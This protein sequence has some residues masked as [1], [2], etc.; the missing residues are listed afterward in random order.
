MSAPK[1]SRV[2][3]RFM[4]N[5]ILKGSWHKLGSSDKQKVKDAMRQ[6]KTFKESKG[7]ISFL[8]SKMTEKAL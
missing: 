7:D 2:T 4:A 3:A 5:Q 6:A 8:T 1:K